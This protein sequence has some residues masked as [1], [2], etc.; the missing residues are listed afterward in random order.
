M[1]FTY[2]KGST[3]DRNRL[4]LLVQDVDEDRLLFE[5]AELDDLLEQEGSVTLA[6]AAVFEALAARY[7]RDYDF[8]ADGASFRKGSVYQAYMVQARR[9]RRR[10]RAGV[11]V[12]PLRKDAYSDDVTSEEATVGGTASFDKG[13]FDTR[14]GET[15]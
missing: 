1:A 9:L 4:R 2:T 11:A 14:T 3:T 6:G 13:Q 12:M 8:S 5:D 10:G 15:S 7:A